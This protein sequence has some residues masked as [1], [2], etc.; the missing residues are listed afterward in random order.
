MN[1]TAT[2]WIFQ[3]REWV[4]WLRLAHRARRLCVLQRR[5]GSTWA[6]GEAGVPCSNPAPPLSC[7]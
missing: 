4:E 1:Y 7:P 5:G 6:A 2:K 3:R